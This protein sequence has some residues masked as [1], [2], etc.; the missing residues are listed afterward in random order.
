QPRADRFLPAQPTGLAAEDEEH[1]LRHVLR[2]LF[3]ADDPPTD[4]EDHRPVSPHQRR[5]RL[6]VTAIGEPLDQFAIWQL[7]L[8]RFRDV[9]RAL[10]HERRESVGHDEPAEETPLDIMLPGTG[11]IR[12]A[13]LANGADV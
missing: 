5:E 11:R 2:V 8:A 6:A 1:G 10:D 12:R 13:F 4:A 7:V 9:A 3:V